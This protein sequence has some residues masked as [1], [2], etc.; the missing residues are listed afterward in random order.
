MLN[1]GNLCDVGFM[2]YSVECCKCSTTY[3]RASGRVCFSLKQLSFVA[4]NYAFRTASSCWASVSL[5]LVLVPPI[6]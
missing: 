2:V 5:Y 1:L 3:G 4:G 6:V